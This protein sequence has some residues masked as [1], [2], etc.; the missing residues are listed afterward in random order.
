MKTQRQIK[1]E[2]QKEEERRRRI[3]TLFIINNHDER[4]VVLY[5]AFCTLYLFCKILILLCIIAGMLG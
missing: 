3:T 5:L 2:G 1:Q 4:F